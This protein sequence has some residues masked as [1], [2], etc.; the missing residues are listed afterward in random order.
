MN[1][2]LKDRARAA[3]AEAIRTGVLVRPEICPAC[4]RPP[5]TGVVEAHHDDYE[6]PLQV[7]WFCKECHEWLHGT[8]R[9]QLAAALANTEPEPA[10]GVSGKPIKSFVIAIRCSEEERESIIQ[11]A[12]RAGAA[13]GYSSTYQLIPTGRR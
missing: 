3:V 12:T 7:R 1:R 2:Y 6:K 13:R 10:M 11:A 9:D 5:L 4:Q 8:E